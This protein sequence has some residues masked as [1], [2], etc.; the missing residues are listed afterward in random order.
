MTAP[1]AISTWEEA[2]S[3]CP[4]EGV[5]LLLGGIDTGKTSLA[6]YLWTCAPA[7]SARLDLDP[8]QGELG[9]PGTLG[10][11]VRLNR[12]RVRRYRYFIGHSSPRGQ[13]VRMLVGARKLLDESRR[14]GARWV[15]IDTCGFIR[16]E[17]G[18][19]TFKG[20]ADRISGAGSCTG[21]RTRRGAR[22]YPGAMA[23]RMA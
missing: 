7:R 5:I 16:R 23:R 18:G 4:S 6:R 3:L 2:R 20:S 13:L 1:L 19:A 14:L 9:P 22:A 8:G 10:G 11:Q 21:P 17:G 15:L 12:A